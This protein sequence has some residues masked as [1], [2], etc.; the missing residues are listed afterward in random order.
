[1]DASVTYKQSVNHETTDKRDSKTKNF[2]DLLTKTYDA[3][4]PNQPL[5]LAYK[6][7]SYETQG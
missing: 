5:Q 7:K 6:N 3:E 2:K 4:C 1:M